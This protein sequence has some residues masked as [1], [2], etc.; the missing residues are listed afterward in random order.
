MNQIVD[1]MNLS[2]DMSISILGR[3]RQHFGIVPKLSSIVNATIHEHLLGGNSNSMFADIVQIISYET[4]RNFWG[5]NEWI[6]KLPTFANAIR[7]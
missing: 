2:L 4:A 6:V 7:H 1:L 5:H 3:H